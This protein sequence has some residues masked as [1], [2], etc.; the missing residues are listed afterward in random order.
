MAGEGGGDIMELVARVDASRETTE[1]L[2]DSFMQGFI[3]QLFRK[4]WDKYGWKLLISKCFT[5]KF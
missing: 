1:L 5:K 2:L 4:K 3:Y